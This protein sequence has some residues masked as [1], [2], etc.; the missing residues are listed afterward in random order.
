VIDN[1][2]SSIQIE[3]K[4]FFEALDAQYRLHEDPLFQKMLSKIDKEVDL[5]WAKGKDYLLEYLKKQD[6][7]YDPKE[8]I[9]DITKEFPEDIIKF[10][11]KVQAIFLGQK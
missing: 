5:F 6:L 1:S 4:E 9:R 8:I 10:P 2:T 3:L 11:S 7:Y